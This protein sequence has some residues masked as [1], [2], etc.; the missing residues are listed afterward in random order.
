L[1]S[2]SDPGGADPW[3]FTESGGQRRR[4]S[5]S[6]RR[7]DFMWPYSM[8]LVALRTIPEVLESEA[9][10]TS[11]LS[12]EQPPENTKLSTASKYRKVANSFRVYRIF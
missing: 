4:Q 10:I 3:G 2:I 9:Q 5:M 12:I 7:L 6:I 8:Q 1:E 11:T